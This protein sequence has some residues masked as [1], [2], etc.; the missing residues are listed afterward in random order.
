MEIWRCAA[1]VGRVG[2]R[3]VW[4]SGG[5]LQARRR[6]GVEVWSSGALEAC[7]GCRDV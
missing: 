4:R 7:C 5:V 6:G 3:E 1:G 2:C